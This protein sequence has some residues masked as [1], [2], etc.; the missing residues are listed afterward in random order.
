MSAHQS[1]NLIPK[2]ELDRR[3]AMIALPALIKSYL[4][5]G[6]LVG[7]GAFIDHDFNCTDVCMVMDTKTLNARAARFY[8]HGVGT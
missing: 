5:L 6:G 8:Q 7:D 4:R 2:E 3:A 1:M